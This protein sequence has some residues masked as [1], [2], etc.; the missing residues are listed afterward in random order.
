MVRKGGWI[1]LESKTKGFVLNR[2]TT[3]QKQALIPVEGMIV[4]DTNLNCV[5]VYNG[6]VWKC[7]NSQQCPDAIK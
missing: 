7:Y 1:A 3:A 2:L 5:S 6:T 4:F